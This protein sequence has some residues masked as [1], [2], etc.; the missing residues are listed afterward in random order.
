MR[1]I[2]RQAA[3]M[4]VLLCAAAVGAQ[5]ADPPYPASEVVGGISFGDYTKHTPIVPATTG[6]LLGGTTTTST[7]PGATGRG[8]TILMTCESAWASPAWRAAPPDVRVIK[9]AQHPDTSTTVV[10]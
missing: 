3:W 2:W 4:G 6:R 7:P 5:A 10:W 9:F 1:A 8:R